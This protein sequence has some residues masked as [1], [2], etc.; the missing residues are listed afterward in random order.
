MIVGV[1]K[2]TFPEEKRVAVIP[3]S[4]DSLVKK[5]FEVIVESGAGEKSGFSDGLYRESG[6]RIADK[7]ERVFDEAEIL[8]QVRGAGA[9]PEKSDPDIELMREGQILVGLLDPFNVPDLI[10]K[11]AEKKITAFALELIPRISKAQGMDVLSSMAT[12]AGYKAVLIAAS[13][14]NRMF[15]LIMTAAGTVRPAHVF[16][17]GAGVA[18]LQAIAT[19]KRL[20]GVVSA[21]DIRKEVREQVESLGAKFI[22]VE[23]DK[24]EKT[25]EKGHAKEMSEEFYKKQRELLTKVVTKNDVIITTAG[26]PGKKPPVLISEGMIEGMKSGSVIV[27]LVAEGGGNCELTEAGKIINKNG[28]KI[29]GALNLPSLLPYN[30]SRLYS[31]NITEFIFYILNNDEIE[32]EDEIAKNTMIT[33]EGKITNSDLKEQL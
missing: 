14:L 6:A 13:E 9:N 17:I 31:K 20:G 11:I 30:A 22:E 18:G 26:V 12:I 23:T 10:R 19:A 7:R 5:D 1:P 15:P 8:L 21:Y 16:V 4:V 28:V 25:E 33:F 24:D 3:E 2:E 32:K 29:V 27:D